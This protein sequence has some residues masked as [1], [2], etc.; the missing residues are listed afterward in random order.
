M[1][2]ATSS[3]V[4]DDGKYALTV[5]GVA[6]CYYVPTYKGL[7]KHTWG[8]GTRRAGGSYGQH[9]KTVSIWVSAAKGGQVEL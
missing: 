9:K 7:N 8:G 3:Q 6:V 4:S 5:G 1:A 2:E